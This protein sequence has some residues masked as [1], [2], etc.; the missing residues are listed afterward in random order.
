MVV[1]AGRR[2]IRLHR[3]CRWLL[4]LRCP[5]EHLRRSWSCRLAGQHFL[6][7]LRGLL[8]HPRP[9]GR[10]CSAPWWSSKN[11]WLHLPP[12][13]SLQ[14]PD[15]SPRHHGFIDRLFPCAFI[16]V[17]V[18]L[19][20]PSPSPDELQR[21]HGFALLGDRFFSQHCILALVW[22]SALRMSF[23]VLCLFLRGALI[24]SL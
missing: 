6:G 20:L 13:L 21:P 22:P 10:N 2:S 11:A 17:F 4:R 3:P 5:N 23:S 12:L 18:E 7:R 14:S 16:V 1:L 8:Q 15:E 19:F 24:M 9:N